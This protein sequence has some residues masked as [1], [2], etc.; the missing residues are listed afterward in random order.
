MNCPHC[1]AVVKKIV[2]RKRRT[3]RGT[4]A[5]LLMQLLTCVTLIPAVIWAIINLRAMYACRMC[6]W[7][8]QPNEYEPV[9]LPWD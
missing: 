8:E 6:G 3:R 2:V 4:C 5:I 9:P 1:N 7:T